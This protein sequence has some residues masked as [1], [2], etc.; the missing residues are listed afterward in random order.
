[1]EQ[2]SISIDCH[3]ELACPN[4]GSTY[5]HQRIVDVGKDDLSIRVNFYC[6]GC[7]NAPDLL[8]WQRKGNTRMMWDSENKFTI[9][10]ITPDGDGTGI[11]ACPKCKRPHWHSLPE[12]GTP[13]HRVAHCNNKTH[14]PDGYYVQRDDM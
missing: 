13:S 2:R 10:M 11:F 3:N 1:M 9:H 12:D 8:I 6:E 5:L 4:C 14:Y 7:N